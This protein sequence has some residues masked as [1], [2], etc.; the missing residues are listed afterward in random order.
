VKH[1]SGT[2]SDNERKWHGKKKRERKSVTF[3]VVSGKRDMRLNSYLLT[4]GPA[5]D[6]CDVASSKILP[7]TDAEW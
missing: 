3:S 6:S 1:C 7:S 5:S 2:I 4:E